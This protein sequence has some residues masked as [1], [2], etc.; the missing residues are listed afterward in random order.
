MPHGGQAY[1]VSTALGR[2]ARRA[3]D[4]HQ[5]RPLALIKVRLVF[6][7]KFSCEIVDLIQSVLHLAYHYA[8]FPLRGFRQNFVR[9]SNP[10]RGSRR[11]FF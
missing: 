6:D 4:A 10:P 2:G 1:A 7:T 3:D 11:C 9:A 5:Q 8:V